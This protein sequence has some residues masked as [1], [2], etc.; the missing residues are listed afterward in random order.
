MQNIYKRLH[1]L[2]DQ[3][4]KVTGEDK[5]RVREELD[6]LR[7]VIMYFSKRTTPIKSHQI[8]YDT[9]IS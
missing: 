6:N 7:R 3:Q 1:F 8:E 2:E 9:F 4:F 5:K